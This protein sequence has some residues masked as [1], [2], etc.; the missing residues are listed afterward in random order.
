MAAMTALLLSAG[1]SAAAAQAIITPAWAKVV[2]PL[3]TSCGFQ[4]V[5]NPVTTRESPI[6]DAVFSS[7]STLGLDYQRFV[8][9]LPY[10]RLGVA[11]LEP[12]TQGVVCGFVNSGGKGNIWNT[13]LDCASSGGGTISAITFAS[14]GRPAGMCAGYAGQ[15]PLKADP[16]CDAAGAKAVV[17]SACVGKPSCTITSS[18]EVFGGA[19]CAGDTRLAVQATCSNSVLTT[20]WDF[21]E[22]D[23]GMVDFLTAADSSNRSTIPNFS[24]IPYWLFKRDHGEKKWYPDDP[25]GETWDY[26]S[27]GDTFL[28]PTYA[29]LGEYYG[30]L[31]AHYV[32]GGFNDEAGR[33][34]PG[35][36][37]T[38]SHWEVLNEVDFEHGLTPVSYTLIYDAIVKGIQ[39]FAPRA[40]TGPNR[41]RFAGLA[42]GNSDSLAYAT[43]FLNASNHEPGIPIDMITFHHYAS[44][45]RRD[46]GVDG[47][48]YE[49]FNGEGDKWL[50]DVSAYI[51]LRDKLNPDVLLDADEVGIILPDD[52]DGRFTSEKPGFGTIFWNAAASNFAYLYGR[53]AV[54]G[55]DV[56]GHSQL[57]GYPSIVFP[58]RPGIGRWEAPPQFPSVALLNWTDG[59]GTAKYWA[60]KL[61]NDV[62]KVGPPSGRYAAADADVVVDTALSLP[63]LV[64]A[65]AFVERAG[66]GARKVLVVNK[67]HMRQNVTLAGAAGATWWYVDPSTGFGPAQSTVLTESTWVLQPF[68]VGFVRMA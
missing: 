20:H 15:T 66:A 1:V 29:T 52:N 61:I 62:V 19:P 3:R 30:R 54:L 40:A 11:A 8:P 58:D 18:D 64:Y 55:L 21:A 49:N 5:V 27:G 35:L 28:D 7:I 33:W 41:I 39:R 4:I 32:E 68:S 16:R 47:S 34:V 6:H 17:E 2:R 25:L 59:S 63:A 51:A 48:L 45:H 31:V 9:W 46:G 24:T 53:T 65:Q 13:T 67:S 38:M 12:P 22:L 23:K 60:T 36:N 14:Y 50:T 56:L 42:L 43:H 10:P 44:C 57:V 37:L 26:E